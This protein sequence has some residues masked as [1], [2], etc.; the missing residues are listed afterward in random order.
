MA[1]VNE[2]W[3]ESGACRGPASELFYAPSLGER[4]EV[5]SDRENKA[6]AICRDLCPV[7]QNCL[8]YAIANREL[9]G[10]WGGLNESERKGLLGM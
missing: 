4:R 5:R 2:S 3:M 6:K 10:I 9:F 8:S 7:R 1:V